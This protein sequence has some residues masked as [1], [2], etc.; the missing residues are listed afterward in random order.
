MTPPPLTLY[1]HVP[2][3]VRKCPYCDFNSYKKPELVPEARFVDVLL[4]DLRQ[5]LTW[6]GKPRELTSIFIGGGTPNLISGNQ[7]I[8]LLTE[9][10]A[11]C[12]W[13]PSMEITMEINAGITNDEWF[14]MYNAAGVNRLSL[15]VQSLNPKQLQALGRIHSTDEVHQTIASARKAG[16]T[17]LNLDLMFGLP[18]QTINEATQDLLQIINLQPQHIS[19]YQLT[20]EPNTIFF[21]KPPLLPDEDLIWM[22]QNQGEEL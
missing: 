5:D 20:I 1:I 8:R 3:C 11:L 15:G 2:W 18:Q 19:W 14:C 17:N 21:R 7:I 16:F 13:R 9:I 22:I 12:S 10:R 6:I 4:Q